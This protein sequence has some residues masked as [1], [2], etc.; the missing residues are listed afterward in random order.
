MEITS[1]Q[2]QNSDCIVWVCAVGNLNGGEQVFLIGQPGVGVLL[3]AGEGEV[4]SVLGVK[5][6]FKGSWSWCLLITLSQRKGLYLCEI[7]GKLLNERIEKR[8]IDQESAIV[9]ETFVMVGFH[10]VNFI[11]W[12]PHRQEELLSVACGGGHQS[13]AYKHPIN[14]DTDP[15]AHGLGQGTLVFT[16]HGAVMASRSLASNEN[17]VNG[18][19]LKEGLHGRGINCVCNL[20]SLKKSRP[21]SELWEVF[22]TGGEDTTVDVLAISPQSGTVKVLS[23]LM[24]HISNVRALAAIRGE[25]NEKGRD[26]IIATSSVS[27]L[28]FSVGGLGQ[29]QCYRLLIH[30]D[31]QQGQPICQVT[32][33]AGHRLDEQWERKR[34]QHKTVKMDPETR[35]VCV[36][37]PPTS[38]RTPRTESK[39]ML[40]IYQTLIPYLNIS[41]TYFPL[42]SF[43]LRLLFLFSVTTDGCISMWDL[44]AVLNSKASV[45]WQGES[46]IHQNINTCENII[47]LAS[48]GD[49][50]QLS[51][52]HIKIDQKGHEN[53]GLSLQ[54]LSH[55]SVPLAHSSPLTVLCLPSPTLLVST[56][57]DQRLCLWSVYSDG[58]RP[59]KVL[60]SHTADWW[61]FVGRAYSCFS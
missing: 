12:D 61:L 53:G 4:H 25:T 24:D 43:G 21:L 39:V 58:L 35:C 8:K 3:R 19:T 50:G 18:H 26:D 31:E 33:I 44:T 9:A 20:G 46:C 55:C 52:W 30:L 37:S 22:V 29:L 6:Q 10:S 27:S 14:I 47:S 60:I 15:Q 1:I 34:N 7:Q 41:W 16:K 28:V 5:G 36:L 13:W 57:L 42:S 40:Y 17:D 49:D 32:Q 54:L 23:V 45:R 59:L 56:S 11:I 48:G 51:L 38:W 2:V